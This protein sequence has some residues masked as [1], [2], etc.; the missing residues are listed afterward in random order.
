MVTM[1]WLLIL[2][3]L[4]VSPLPGPGGLIIAPIG[5]ALILKNSL[6]AKKRYARFSRNHPAYGQ[7][8]NWAIGRSK[9]KGKPSLPNVKGDILFVF[10]RDDVGKKLP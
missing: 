3:A 8:T 2:A 6:W 4:A 5:I 10:R 7:W 9:M 1:G